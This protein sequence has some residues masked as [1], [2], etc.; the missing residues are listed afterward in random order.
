MRLGRNQYDPRESRGAGFCGAGVPPAFC[1]MLF[2]AKLKIEK[3]AGG[4]PEP[5]EK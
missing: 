1:S 2:C 5:L 4:T 3:I